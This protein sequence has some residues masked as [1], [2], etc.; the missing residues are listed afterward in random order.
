[1]KKWVKIDR[2]GVHDIEAARNVIISNWPERPHQITPASV[3]LELMD[4]FSNATY[5]PT[6][7]VASIEGAG[8]IGVAGW[9]GAWHNYGVY[10]L[11][12][13]NV[14]E[15]YRGRGIGRALIDARLDDIREH[16]KNDHQPVYVMLSTH[17]PDLYEKFE[18]KSVSKLDLWQ[19]RET[20]LMVRTL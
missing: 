19:G 11:F 10:E 3:T 6:Y 5:R 1:M 9:N 20:H 17:I 16:S 18:F 14:K 8:I 15:E 12:W 13:G 4:A 7:F 2:M